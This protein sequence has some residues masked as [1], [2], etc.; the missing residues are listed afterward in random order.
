MARPR[1]EQDAQ[2]AILGFGSPVGKTGA[3]AERHAGGDKPVAV[4]AFQVGISRIFVQGLV[5]VLVQRPVQVDDFFLSQQHHQVSK[6]GFAERGCR[7]NRLL[8]VACAVALIPVPKGLL[9][10]DLRVVED[11]AG[12]PGHVR[13]FH[14]LFDER[15]QLGS[16]NGFAIDRL[17]PGCGLGGARPFP[18]F[19]H[20]LEN[21]I[22][23]QLRF[24][25]RD[26]VAGPGS[27]DPRAVGRQSCQLDL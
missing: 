17:Q 19:I 20:Q 14:G 27:D 23:D 8:I 6:H 13:F 12:E 18:G 3:V 1:C 26:I 9:V 15:L 2:L 11:G 22:H 24:L 7:E 4:V 16:R 21:G 25:S 5:Q 10:H